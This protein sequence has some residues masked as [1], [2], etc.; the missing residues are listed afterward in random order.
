MIGRNAPIRGVAREKAYSVASTAE[1]EQWCC[2]LA[3]QV[4]RLCPLAAAG[5]AGGSEKHLSSAVQL[6]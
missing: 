6:L 4:L 2:E 1:I 3:R 5:Q